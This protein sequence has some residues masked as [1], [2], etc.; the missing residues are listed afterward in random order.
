MILRNIT[1]NMVPRIYPNAPPKMGLDSINPLS[2]DSDLFTHTSLLV[3]THARNQT[4]R[5]VRESEYIFLP[6]LDKT[7][8]AQSTREHSRR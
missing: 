1:I 7:S 2:S 8:P 5:E 4:H 3:H 6:L